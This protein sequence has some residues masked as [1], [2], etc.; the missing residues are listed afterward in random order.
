MYTL[1]SA[2]TLCKGRDGMSPCGH[3]HSPS[4]TKHTQMRSTAI[5]NRQIYSALIPP[6][7]A[8]LQT[9]LNWPICC[10]V[11]CFDHESLQDLELTQTAPAH[12]GK[13]EDLLEARLEAGHAKDMALD[14]GCITRPLASFHGTSLWRR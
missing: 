14:T 5:A 10:P 1:Y 11:W 9:L 8:P 2:H 12:L 7:S 13:G 6:P 4:G 3:T